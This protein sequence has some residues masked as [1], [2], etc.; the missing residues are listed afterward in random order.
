M[1]GAVAVK[2][3]TRTRIAFEVKENTKNS[4]LM[5]FSWRRENVAEV[6][7]TESD[8]WSCVSNINKFANQ[9]TI[10]GRVFLRKESAF[11]RFQSRGVDHWSGHWSI[12]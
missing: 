3:D 2:E 4:L 8:V 6:V 1:N 10:C 11:R 7:Y 9:T 12:I 5:S